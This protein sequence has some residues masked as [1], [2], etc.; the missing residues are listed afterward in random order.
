MTR[1]AAVVLQQQ[2]DWRPALI[3]VPGNVAGWFTAYPKGIILH[4]TRS[5]NI[6]YSESEEFV[7]TVNFV[8]AGAGGLG[9]NALVGPAIVAEHMGLTEWGWNAREHSPEYLAVEVAQPYY[10]APISDATFRA[11]VWYLR[12]AF[13]LWA[14]LVPSAE[15][16]PYHSELPAGRRDGKSDIFWPQDPEGAAFRDRLIEALR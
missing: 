12:R 13:G 1:R 5:G 7:G 9:W 14:S 15:T 2:A 16:L 11:L 10:G 6:Y 3:T 8:K 4:A